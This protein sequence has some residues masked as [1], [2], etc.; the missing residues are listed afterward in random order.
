M[1]H[2]PLQAGLAD[3]F[4]ISQLLT[5]KPA[6]TERIHPLKFHQATISDATP[7]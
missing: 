6:S 7:F 3:S 4:A 2:C 5:T 1:I